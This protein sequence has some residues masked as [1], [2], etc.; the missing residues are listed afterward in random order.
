MAVFKIEKNK[1]YIIMSNYH[2]RDKNISLK[3][4]GLLSF[5]LSLP[6]D[7]DYS[8]NGLCKKAGV[9]CYQSG[10]FKSEKNM[11]LKD[12][13]RIAKECSGKDKFSSYNM[14]R[15]IDYSMFSKESLDLY[16]RLLKDDIGK[17]N[18][19]DI[20]SSGYVIDTLEASLWVLLK[21]KNYKESIIGAINLGND[22]DTIGAI[23]GS[24][25]GIIYGYDDIPKKW[26]D[27]FFS[28]I[29]PN[30]TIKV[31]PLNETPFRKMVNDIIVKKKV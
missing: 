1:N 17:F 8:L 31:R 5:M 6:D 3:A 26:L 12:F 2:L 10:L 25:S 15:L 24:M 22:T 16:S 7:W 14:V 28:G 20:K 29:N 13:E 21:S 9:E 30:F 4:K 18:I 11:S 19:D 27:I 23:T